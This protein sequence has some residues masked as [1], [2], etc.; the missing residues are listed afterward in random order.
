MFRSA[1][2]RELAEELE[3]H[4]RREA[5]KL[6]AEG[7][8]AEAALRAAR[9]RFGGEE[10]FKEQARESWGVTALID[11]GGDVRFAARQ[12]LK[13]P[14]F[15]AVAVLTLALGIGGTVAL[16]SVVYGLLLRPL[17][18]TDEARIVTWWS[19]Y[20]WRGA[21]FDYIREVP[22]AYEGIAAFSN[23]GYTL[24]TE[25]GATLVLATVG[26]AELFD[27]LD[28]PPM[29][30]RTFRSGE[31]R[32][33]AEPVVVLGHPLWSQEL[34]ADPEVVGRRVNLGGTL[35]TVIG[36]MPEG[37]YFPTPDA[38]V[39]VPL[40]LDP[41][42]PAY[43]GNGWLVLMGRLLPDVTDEQLAADLQR[44]AVA[45]GEE[46][47]YPAAWDKTRNPS[48]L[49][50]R[51]H[52]LGD[53]RPVLLVLLGA[54]GLLLLIA[55]V[56]VAALLLTKTVDRRREVAV[57][58]VL[59]AGRA[60]LARQVLTESVLLGVVAGALGA[61][62]AVALFDVMVASMPI[63]PSFRE[64]LVLDWVTLLTA[65]LLAVV[66]GS[67]I[68]IAPMRS[69]LRGDVSGV[70]LTERSSGA[71]GAATSRM[72]KGLVVAEVLLAVVLVTGA[73]LLVRT[74]DR[75]QA[76]DPGFEP[77]GVLTMDVLLSE[78]ERSGAERAAFHEAFL[79]R[80]R[81]LPGVEAVGLLNRLPLR[82]G[83]YQATA[84]FE[85]RPELAGA[86]RP[87]V[88]YRPMTPEA[89]DV[90]G[91][92]IVE[93]RAVS[94]TDRS[95]APSV[96]VINESFARRIWEGESAIGRTFTH[97]FGAGQ[98]RVVGVV[99]DMAVT[100]LV[101]EQPMTAYYPWDQAERG[102]A[103]AIVIAKASSGDPLAL[104]APLR[105]LTNELEAGA[106]IGRVATLEE[107]LDAEMAEALRLRFFLGLF[108]VLGMVLGSVGVYGVVSYSVQR[109]RAEFGIRRALGAGRAAL[110]GS[111]LGTGLA[112]VALGVGA[113]TLVA[114]FSST[115]L[116]RFLFEV[117]PVDPV[118]MLVAAGALM[119]AGVV[120]A[121]LPALR[122]SATPPAVALRAE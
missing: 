59:G 80:A 62:L 122:A 94:P 24:R 118:S 56:N 110:L 8:S 31:D 107:A 45:L 50:I 70:A 7:M 100:D 48:V 99:R 47:E 21:E 88:M 104:A 72:Q 41:E 46:Y 29:L 103:G 10:R 112:P 74:V 81:S 60:R 23:D 61:G 85:D 58:A 82:D 108:S 52:L 86:N 79:E 9:I 49:P 89:F 69:L 66:S 44:T 36:V 87:N 68:A 35:R 111:V 22:R 27:V 119:G 73:S 11:L 84:G 77:E 117:A 5:E 54:V 26:S 12:L 106:A 91:A 83:G 109:R 101:G 63:D 120:A 78:D 34:G 102:S 55:C 14:T 64:T 38:D 33:G 114:L 39:Y 17:P 2:E 93:G 32:P 113:G 13:S 116:S 76:V 37:F 30:G 92:G 98:I 43:A 97:G 42:D 1:M 95:D 67:L 51:D 121:L 75:L 19:A 115:L 15:S 6:R 90:L 53:V 28:V 16:S 3:Y 71:G 57:R 18:M 65:L 25:R 20:N 40:S 105:A 4:V 96:A